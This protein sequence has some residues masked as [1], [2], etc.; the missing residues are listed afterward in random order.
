MKI[1][2]GSLYIHHLF[3]FKNY[4]KK[5][6]FLIDINNANFSSDSNFVWFSILEFILCYSLILDK[7]VFSFQ[8]DSNNIK[9]L[10]PS[11]EDE[12]FIITKRNRI[13]KF[14]FNLFQPLLNFKFLTKF[15]NINFNFK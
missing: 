1:E 7:I 3:D 8:F 9:E 12:L 2:K 4:K 11:P 5:F 6:T 14:K 15:N 13:I 10:I